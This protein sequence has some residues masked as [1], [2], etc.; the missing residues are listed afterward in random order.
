MPRY[1]ILSA[2]HGNLKNAANRNRVVRTARCEALR[3]IRVS[4]CLNSPRRIARAGRNAREIMI[5]KIEVSGLGDYTRNVGYKTGS[6]N[7]E[8]ETKTF[9]CDR[10]IRLM[11]D[12][13]D[14]EEVGVLARGLQGYLL[15]GRGHDRRG[16]R[17]GRRAE[18][19]RRGRTAHSPA[20]RPL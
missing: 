2:R 6:I 11:A 3:A 15:R 19:S 10:G 20:L 4:A 17:H 5:P 16:D 1:A 8:F 9:D 14:V 18:G 13:M 12:V 7:Y